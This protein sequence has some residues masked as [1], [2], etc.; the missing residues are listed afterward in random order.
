MAY[1]GNLLSKTL[2]IGIIILF[3]GMS[4]VTST[5]NIVEDISSNTQVLDLV[6]NS[7]DLLLHR[8][9]ACAYIADPGS[10]GHPEGP[11]YF[12]LDDPGNI[13]SLKSTSSDNIL[14]GGT[15]GTDVKW[16]GCEYNS[17][18]LWEI[19][20][21]TGDMW[22]IGGGGTSCYGLAWDLVYTRLYATDGSNLI[23]YNIETGEQELIGSHGQSGKTMVGLAINKQGVCYAWNVLFSGTSTLFI[24]D[25]NSGEADEVG[26]MGE[27]LVSAGYG[28]FDWHTGILYISAS[29]K[30]MKCNLETGGLTMVGDFEGGAE[31]TALAIPY[32]RFPQANFI[33]TPIHPNPGEMILFNA[34]TSYDQDGYIT[35]YSWDWDDDGVF[36][37]NHTS[38]T[39]THTFDEVGYYP[40]TLRVKDNDNRT[41][42]KTKTVRVGNQPPE[43]PVIDGP[44]SG[45]PDVEYEF[46]IIAS[47]LDN[48]T[49]F[50]LWNWVDGTGSD[51]IGP[52]ESGM[53]VCDSHIWNETG[54]YNISVTVRDEH[55]ASA[56]VYKE[57]TIPRIRVSYS[58]VFLRFLDRFPL[59]EVFL[60]TMNLLR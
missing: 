51:W 8:K 22:S 31:L 48:D 43:T 11:C 28:A 54:T 39:S 21:E 58:S 18:C 37:V 35:L 3:I 34:S 19:D 20:H 45:I 47:D 16:R 59:L 4:I 15:W 56:T 40:V 46:C 7:E 32:M 27:P 41:V 10:S 33:W 13:T 44:N 55:G 26:S 9:I 52:L 1:K 38:P 5:G 49:L 2:V 14:T 6:D 24:I 17:G 36:D 53:E 30:L 12:A 29:G 57:V 23:E 60:R 42:D 25:L 50:V